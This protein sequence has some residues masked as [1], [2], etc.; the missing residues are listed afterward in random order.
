MAMAYSSLSVVVGVV[1][2]FTFANLSS[3]IVNSVERKD[4]CR[5]NVLPPGMEVAVVEEAQSPATM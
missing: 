3:T 5:E 1:S 2:F 4:T